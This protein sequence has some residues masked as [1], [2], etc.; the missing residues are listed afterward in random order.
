V[1]LHFPKNLRGRAAE[2]RIADLRVL[3]VSA[4]LL[5]GP[6]TTLGTHRTRPTTPSATLR[7]L[8]SIIPRESTGNRSRG[9]EVRA[10][11]EPGPLR[12][13]QN[14]CLRPRLWVVEFS[15]HL[16][17]VFLCSKI[18]WFRG[19]PDAR[20]AYQIRGSCAG[21]RRNHRSRICTSSI[22][23]ARQPE[24]PKTRP[25]SHPRTRGPSRGRKATEQSGIK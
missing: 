9:S 3:I 2:H 15:M 21:T 23:R 17:R 22:R 24:G 14:T 5:V 11:T 10:P 1:S 19:L 7:A 16:V 25:D 13:V 8:H 18:N 20:E 6:S 4:K 12:S